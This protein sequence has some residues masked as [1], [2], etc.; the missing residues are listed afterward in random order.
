MC[1]KVA[2]LNLKVHTHTY[3]NTNIFS[4]RKQNFFFI[5]SKLKFEWKNLKMLGK[6]IDLIFVKFLI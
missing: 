4:A 6:Q 5:F 3:L 2:V 1:L